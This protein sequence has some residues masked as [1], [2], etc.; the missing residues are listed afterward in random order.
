[1]HVIFAIMVAVICIGGIFC[2]VEFEKRVDLPQVK[3]DTFAQIPEPDPSGLCQNCALQ[4][5]C[6]PRMKCWEA[7]RE[8]A[9]E[10]LN[11]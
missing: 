1:M 4:P 2:L 7:Y 9:R 5:W 3:R 6:L 11:I 8:A 10:V